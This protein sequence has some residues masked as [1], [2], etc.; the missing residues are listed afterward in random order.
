MMAP[1]RLGV[2]LRITQMLREHPEILEQKITK[3]IIIAGYV[4]SYGKSLRHVPFWES[5]SGGIEVDPERPHM[6]R[7]AERLMSSLGLLPTLAAMH[8]VHDVHQP[9]EE[10]GWGAL[11]MRSFL[12]SLESELPH[13][14]FLAV[15]PASAQAR[16]RAIKTIMQIKQWKEG[17]QQWF[18]KSPEHLNGV[19][20]LAEAFPDAKVVTIH[21]DEVSVYKSLLILFQTTRTMTFADL[22]IE[23]SKHATDVQLCSQ[24]RGLAAVPNLNVDSLPLHFHDVIGK[25]IDTLKQVA[26]FL[27][28]GWNS[29]IEAKAVAAV[30]EASLKKKRMGGKMIYQVEK[31]GLTEEMIRER[32]GKCNQ[33][34]E[35]MPLESSTHCGHKANTTSKANTSFSPNV[36]YSAKSDKAAVL[37]SEE[38]HQTASLATRA[39]MP[40]F[41]AGVSFQ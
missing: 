28:L 34:F 27:D 41:S 8:E 16:Y 4:R 3:P 9:E 37:L 15:E 12:I 19:K 10:L 6:M 35:D 18:F 26:A 30:E 25:P 14:D 23:R 21:R 17:P 24:K 5:L 39:G 33:Y 1:Q 29:T 11:T 13:L 2:H 7:W 38:M 40:S 22:S 32:L 31:F 20:E 36:F